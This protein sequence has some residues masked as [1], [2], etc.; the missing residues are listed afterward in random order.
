[1][2]KYR[3][4]EEYTCDEENALGEVYEVHRD[5]IVGYAN[6]IDEA[7]SIIIK[8]F[9]G[10]CEEYHEPDADDY[11]IETNTYPYEIVA[12]TDEQVRHINK[13]GRKRRWE[14]R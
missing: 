14:D 4:R 2:E 1:M 5:E 8:A 6:T 3:I 9:V 13:E 10:N 7:I 11:K 12:L